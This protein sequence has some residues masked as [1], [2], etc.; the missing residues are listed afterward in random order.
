MDNNNSSFI[1]HLNSSV[2]IL[3]NK[4]LQKRTNKKLITELLIL[5]QQRRTPHTEWWCKTFVKHCV[6]NYTLI[7]EC[8][9][10]TGSLILYF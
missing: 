6:P 8:K 10:A 2:L 9:Y 5:Q 1:L 7:V 4:S 3:V